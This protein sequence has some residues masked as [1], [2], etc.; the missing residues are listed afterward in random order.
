MTNIFEIVTND[1]TQEFK[2]HIDMEDFTFHT[3]Y[4]NEFNIFELVI[5]NDAIEIFK[6]IIKDKLFSKEGF[7][8]NYIS[9]DNLNILNIAISTNSTNILKYLLDEDTFFIKNKSPQAL[10][11]IFIDSQD[12]A[13]INILLERNTFDMLEKDEDGNTALMLL[14]IDMASLKLNI[15]HTFL[16]DLIKL[17]DS[18]SY[19]FNLKNNHHQ[20]IMDIAL[21]NQQMDV[22]VDLKKYNAKT[23]SANEVVPLSI[24][25]DSLSI[26]NE[27]L[28]NKTIKRKDINKIICAV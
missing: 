25:S 7:N 16:L 21:I 28:I 9:E 17:A 3:K 27:A 24:S 4:E 15:D 2:N 8:K 11:D 6:H 12:A 19:D 22:I 18:Y 13:T 1:N 10:E 5:I 26:L 23:F 20:T 14:F